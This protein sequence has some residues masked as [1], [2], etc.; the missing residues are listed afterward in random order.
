MGVGAGFPRGW[1][2]FLGIWGDPAVTGKATGNDLRERKK[3]MPVAM[4]LSAGV[5]RP[6]SFGPSTT[7]TAI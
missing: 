7:S 5:R 3:S 1:T 6:M 4:V 2:T